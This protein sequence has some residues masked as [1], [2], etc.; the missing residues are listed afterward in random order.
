[1]SNLNFC[2]VISEKNYQNIVLLLQVTD[3]ALYHYLIYNWNDN[4]T[5]YTINLL[6][7]FVLGKAF[8]KY[9]QLLFLNIKFNQENYQI[10]YNIIIYHQFECVSNFEHTTWTLIYIIYKQP[11]IEI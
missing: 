11:N 5:H 6:K 8:T 2:C 7:I 10:E 3:N 4:V 1:M 9:Q